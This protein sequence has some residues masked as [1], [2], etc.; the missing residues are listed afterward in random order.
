M[1]VAEPKFNELQ[2]SNMS[3]LSPGYVQAEGE[4]P[5]ESSESGGYYPL[6]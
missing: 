2:R 5:G 6:H 4:G 1:K 3:L